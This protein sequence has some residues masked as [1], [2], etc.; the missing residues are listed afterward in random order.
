[1]S[2]PLLINSRPKQDVICRMI[3]YVDGTSQRL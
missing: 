2:M 3:K 1:M